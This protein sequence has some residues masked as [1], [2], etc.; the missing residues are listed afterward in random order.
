MIYNL[1]RVDHTS[2]IRKAYGLCIIYACMNNVCIICLSYLLPINRC[3]CRYSKMLVNLTHKSYENYQ[4][5][6]CKVE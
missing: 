6:H 4:T 3:T 2:V 5:V 1:A